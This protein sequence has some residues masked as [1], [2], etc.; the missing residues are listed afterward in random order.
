MTWTELV[1]QVAERAGVPRQTARLVLTT[2]MEV[3]VEWL[4]EGREVPLR[5]I[6]AVSTRWA[7]GRVLRSV[8]DQRKMWVG[9]RFVPRFRPSET[10]RRALG[11]RTDDTWRSPSHQQAWRLAETLIGDLDLYHGAQ[12]PKGLD[13]SLSA[14]AIESACRGAFG[15]QWDHVERSYQERVERQAREGTHYLGIAAKRR[16]VA[17]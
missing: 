13:G 12:A 3:A 6:G 17:S 5:G 4:R 9:G 15:S 10:L 2:T 16:W 1:D 8:A 11:E 7:E 14:E